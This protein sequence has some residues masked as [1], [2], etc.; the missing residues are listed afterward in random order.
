MIPHPLPQPLG[1]RMRYLLDTNI[2]IVMLKRKGQDGYNIWRRVRQTP[3]AEITFS[4]VVEAELLHGA[5][6][7]H[8]P[9]QRRAQ[10]QIVLSP[11]SSLPFDAACALHYAR[12]R[13]ELELKRQVIG[14]NDLLIAATALAHGLTLVTRNTG[15]FSRVPGLQL[16]DW[17]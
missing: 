15:E 13:H 16:E 17:S 4:S 1:E 12:I 2:F 11:F 3:A 14:A 8:A 7:Y 6:K 10:L 9:E 5:E